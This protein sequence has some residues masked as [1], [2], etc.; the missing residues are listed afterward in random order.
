MNT[1]SRVL[2]FILLA[3]SCPLILAQDFSQKFDPQRDA[4]K[5]VIAAQ[6]L[7]KAAG[8][9][10]LVD[11]GG[12]W[13]RWCRMLDRLIAKQPQIK[14]FLDSHY[15]WT[16]VSYSA[17]NKNEAVL[18][19]W[20]KARGYPYLLVLDGDGRLLHAQGV[21]GLEIEAEDEADEDYDPDRVMAFLK[22]YAGAQRKGKS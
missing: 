11:V 18:S 16:K 14:A 22:R 6:T 5:D 1:L 7:A 8:K 19:R 15:V 9:R 13:C 17:E 3:F 10:V 12:E 2:I 4:A 21:H 20:P